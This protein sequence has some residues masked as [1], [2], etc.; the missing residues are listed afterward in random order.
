MDTL[1][2]HKGGRLSLPQDMLDSHHWHAGTEFT[3]EDR[4][5]GLLLRPLQQR[6][7]RGRE[8]TPG[9]SAG[10]GSSGCDRALADAMR[11][12]YARLGH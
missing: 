7:K 5:E 9:H 11:D 10:D 4:P 1:K 8:K 3:V 6:P 2:L 12:R